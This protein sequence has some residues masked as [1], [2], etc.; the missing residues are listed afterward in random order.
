MYQYVDNGCFLHTFL[1][2]TFKYKF[3]AYNILYKY[4]NYYIIVLSINFTGVPPASANV[5]LFKVIQEFHLLQKTTGY[6]FCWCYHINESSAIVSQFHLKYTLLKEKDSSA[7]KSKGQ[8]TVFWTFQGS[9]I[10]ILDQMQFLMLMIKMAMQ[11]LWWS[12]NLE[13]FFS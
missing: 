2:S 6:F 10:L 5:L 4:S 1:P 3:H 11:L 8:N 7:T 9:K 12:K 13:K